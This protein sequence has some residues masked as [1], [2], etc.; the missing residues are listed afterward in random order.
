MLTENCN[1]AE[2]MHLSYEQDILQ[3]IQHHDTNTMELLFQPLRQHNQQFAFLLC[4]C[5]QAY[6]ILSKNCQTCSLYDMNY[7]TN[8]MLKLGFRSAVESTLS[9][10][11]SHSRFDTFFGTLTFE[12]HPLATGSNV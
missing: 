8:G 1:A 4:F 5:H 11:S 12:N 2:H 9:F 3:S 7:T 6:N 10:L